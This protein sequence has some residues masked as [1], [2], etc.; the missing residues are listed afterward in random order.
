MEV[1]A[2]VTMKDQ[3][4]GTIMA[5]D[6]GD[7]TAWTSLTSCVMAD[8]ALLMAAGLMAAAAAARRPRRRRGPD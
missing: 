1:P 6:T 4:V 8:A 3:S 5:V 7:Y 2:I